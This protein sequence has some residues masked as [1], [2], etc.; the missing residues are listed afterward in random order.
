LLFGLLRV[1]FLDR[2]NL[3][4]NSSVKKLVEMDDLS[5]RNTARGNGFLLFA[6]SMMHRGSDAQAARK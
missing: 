6:P 3:V 1:I 2:T 4:F 5:E